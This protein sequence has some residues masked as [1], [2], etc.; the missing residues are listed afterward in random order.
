[1]PTAVRIAAGSPLGAANAVAVAILGARIQAPTPLQAMS[2]LAQTVLVGGV[3]A[4]SVLGAPLVQ[5]GFGWLAR[6]SASGPLGDPHALARIALGS[7]IAARGPLGDPQALAR[8]IRGSA[9]G[10]TTTSYGTHTAFQRNT[11]QGFIS[12]SFGTPTSPQL[13]EARASGWTATR[14]GTPFASQGIVVVEVPLNFACPAFGFSST[15]YGRPNSAH[16]Q[17]GEATGTQIG[18]VGT[19]SGLAQRVHAA[20]FTSTILSSEATVGVRLRQTG[21]RLTAFGAPNAVAV[22]QHA[23]AQP[24]TRFGTARASRV[25]DHQASSFQAPV[26]F[27]RP[28]GFSRFNYPASGFTSTA[29]GTPTCHERHRVAATASS[30]TF[31]QPLLKRAP[32]C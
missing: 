6:I 8:V 1:M 31:G 25:G 17:I 29:V 10:F 15:R 21:A 19:P 16:T 18:A 3:Q 2:A 4:P 14:Y 26:R 22:L 23:A 24:T 30:T 9:V 27:G 20:G 12:T 32:T 13:I 7:R 5:A 28:T 11:T